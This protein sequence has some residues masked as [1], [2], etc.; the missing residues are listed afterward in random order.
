V[1]ILLRFRTVR[2][3]YAETGAWMLKP[4]GGCKQ[5]VYSTQRP[6]AC[7]ASSLAAHAS[8]SVSAA[9]WP[10]RPNAR[11]TS[12]VARCAVPARRMWNRPVA[13]RSTTVEPLRPAASVPP[14]HTSWHCGAAMQKLRIVR[15][16]LGTW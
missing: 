16:G 15:L 7:G 8:Y 4:F 13:V 9:G 10:S 5:N 6:R 1:G 3:Q 11:S 12:T 14:S 2:G